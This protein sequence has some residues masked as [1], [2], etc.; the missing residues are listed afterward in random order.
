MEEKDIESLN[1]SKNLVIALGSN[2]DQERNVSFAME[3]LRKF[4]PD[5]V[6]SKML[7]TEPIGIVSDRFVNA[8]G[9]ASTSM[10]QQQVTCVL[11]DIERKCG[12]CQEDKARNVV[13][14][15]LDLMQYGGERLKEADWDRGYVQQLLDSDFCL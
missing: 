1:V 4:F 9:K 8:L 11:K 3:E 5:M 2:F 14:L 12:R 13:K 7:W 15:D 6:F 10:S